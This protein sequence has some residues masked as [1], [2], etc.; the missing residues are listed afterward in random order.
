MNANKTDTSR[1][2]LRLCYK[3][4]DIRIGY[5]NGHAKIIFQVF[6][7]FSIAVIIST[8]TS[9]ENYATGYNFDRAVLV[10]N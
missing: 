1:V 3:E 6:N 5:C 9:V 4:L 7:L 2:C 8:H 10:V